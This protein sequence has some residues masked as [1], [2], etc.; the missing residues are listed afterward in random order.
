L[1]PLRSGDY[2]WHL[3]AGQWSVWTGDVL[4]QNLFLYTLPVDEPGL[5]QPWLAQ[6]ILLWLHEHVGLSGSLLCRNMLVCG[7][8]AALSLELRKQ[9]TTPPMMA[10]TLLGALPIMMATMTLRTHLF[11]WPLFLMVLIAMRRLRRAQGSSLWLAGLVPV[12]ALWVQLHGSFLLPAV[13]VVM[14]VV[15]RLTDIGRRWKTNPR[16]STI[17]GCLGLAVVLALTPVM[18]PVGLFEVYAY[19]GDVSADPIVRGTV[20][21]WMPT[22]PGTFPVMAPLLYIWL[23]VGAWFFFQR[24][25]MFDRFDFI[26]FF[27]F[28]LLA[29][30]QARGL[31]WFAMVAPLTLTPYLPGSIEDI[32][33][34]EEVPVPLQLV[35]VVMILVCA[36]MAISTQPGTI[37]RAEI[38]P[39]AAPV[40][41][42]TEQ[43]WAMLV[44][45]DTPLDATRWLVNHPTHRRL[46]HDQRWAGLLLWSLIEREKSTQMVFVDQRIELPGEQVWGLYESIGQARSAWRLQLEAHDVTAILADPINQKPLHDALTR[47]VTW[48]N[49]VSTEDYTLFVLVKPDV[50]DVP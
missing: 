48:V 44:T 20:T 38:A 21:E 35:H 36:V 27:G 26:V 8:L 24:R 25:R 15:A 39:L 14:W 19:L 32:V 50:D 49:T 5:S 17:V 29:L 30:V 22:T 6:R 12:G 9:H 31:L 2:W 3:V 23:L 28:G 13:L 7:G 45:Q 11:V 47:D 33:E 18:H 4:T 46:F 16:G 42:R 1:L 10:I 40:P 34:D 37:T 43:P 41:L